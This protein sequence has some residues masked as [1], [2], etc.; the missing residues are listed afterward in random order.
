M[1]AVK[2][3]E[4][5]L[6]LV[7]KFRICLCYVSRENF[8]DYDR[9]SSPPTLLILLLDI[10]SYPIVLISQCAAILLTKEI[11]TCYL[12]S[13]SGKLATATGHAMQIFSDLHYSNLYKCIAFYLFKYNFFSIAW[14][15]AMK[16]T[17]FQFKKNCNVKSILTENQVISQNIKRPNMGSQMSEMWTWK[18]ITNLVPQGLPARFSMAASS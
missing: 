11:Y 9:V 17:H 18:W 7:E 2:K 5:L 3:L 8:F 1:F 16:K 6:I 14:P 4:A 15:V 13:C 10:D 12:R